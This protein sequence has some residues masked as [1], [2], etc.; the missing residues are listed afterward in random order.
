MEFAT[1]A[2][3]APEFKARVER[4]VWCSVTTVNSQGRPRTRVLHPIWEGAVG[5]IAT[6]RHSFKEKHLA[7]NPYVSL[8]YIDTQL[9]P[10][11]VDCKTSWVD[12]PTE[13][14]RIWDLYN[15]TPPPV[16]YELAPFF[17]SVDSPGYGVL[18]LTPWRVELASLTA[19]SKI[20]RTE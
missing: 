3:L 7:A 4:I 13:K 1:F 18:R 5:S 14:Q 16:G 10:T 17:G 11:Y 8:C 2:E 9:E 6:G 19:E 20:W 15:N 12:D